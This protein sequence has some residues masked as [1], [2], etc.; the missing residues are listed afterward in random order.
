MVR[1]ELEALM[2]S[3]TRV[4][5]VVFPTPCEHQKPRP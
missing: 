2:A 3:N 4:T 5:S 1:F